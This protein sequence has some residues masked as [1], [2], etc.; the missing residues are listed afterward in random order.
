MHG[1]TERSGYVD[2][3]LV[4]NNPA[5]IA[6]T[7]TVAT[8]VCGT[9]DRPRMSPGKALSSIHLLSVGTGRN[10]VGKA[11][12]L[13]P[14]FTDGSAAWGYR[15]WILDPSNPLVLIDAFLQAGNEAVSWQ[16]N[17]LMGASHFHRLNVPLKHMCV[18]NDP[19]TEA[20]VTDSA[21]WLNT[22]GWFSE[23]PRGLAAF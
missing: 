4:A 9:A 20:L 23:G 16:C 15:Q 21:N 3:G 1:G 5:M 7:S 18:I 11:Q 10:L 6:L 2:G 8:L 19:E 22:T 13:A 17:I 14:E 12:Y